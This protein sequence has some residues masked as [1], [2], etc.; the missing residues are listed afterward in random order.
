M[1]R[2]PARLRPTRPPGTRDLT[3]NIGRGEGVS[4]REMIDRINTL[5]G[6]DLPP[7]VTERRAGDPARVVASADRIATELGWKARHDVENMITS[8]WAGW[9]RRHPEAGRSV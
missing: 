8:A 7:L 1:W 2:R 5:T 9:L 4:V 6:Y 3:L